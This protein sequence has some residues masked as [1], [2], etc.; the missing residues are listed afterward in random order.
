MMSDK[1]TAFR[2]VE[3]RRYYACKD[4]KFCA[5]NVDNA[6]GADDRIA[7]WFG[8]VVAEFFDA[9]DKSVAEFATARD[10][11]VAGLAGS[12]AARDAGVN[13]LPRHNFKFGVRPLGRRAFDLP[14]RLTMR[15]RCGL[16][17][18]LRT[19]D[20]RNFSRCRRR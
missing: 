19:W 13:Q 1:A 3:A 14:P 10:G 16:K 15:S 11:A 6:V 4:V 18:E 17:P 9:R 8:S 12:E 2:N 20:T 7:I 5:A